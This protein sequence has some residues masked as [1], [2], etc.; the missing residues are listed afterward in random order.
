MT[1][2]LAVVGVIWLFSCA[3]GLAAIRWSAFSGTRRFR[4]AFISSCLAIVS[5]WLGLSS[6]QVSASKTVNGQVQWS[7]NSKWFFIGALVLAF[8]SLMLTAWNWR[9]TRTQPLPL[10]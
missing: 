4:A 10:S 6:L 5:A 8:G 7:F 9:K 2:L 1:V 3:A